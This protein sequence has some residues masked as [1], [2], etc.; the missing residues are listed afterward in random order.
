MQVDAAQSPPA[1]AASPSVTAATV[2]AIPPPA[3]ASTHSNVSTTITD[4]A[5]ASFN[6]SD[7]VRTALTNTF[8]EY[9]TELKAL[10]KAQSSLD[11]FQHIVKSTDG[12]LPAGLR[13]KI[14]KSARFTAVDT[15]DF[16]QAEMT[17][18]KRIELTASKQIAETM[19]KAKQRLIDHLRSIANPIS[20]IT[21]AVLKFT[22]TVGEYAD[23]W[24][25]KLHPSA[26]I[27]AS[28]AAAPATSNVN[29]S[30]RFPRQSA[31]EHFEREL[32][33]KVDHHTTKEIQDSMLAKAAE[34]A[35]VT[36]ER[37][38]KERVV[39]GV[40]TRELITDIATQATEK[41]V[42]A[43]LKPLKRKLRQLET[44]EANAAP[45]TSVLTDAP[46]PKRARTSNKRAQSS[47]NTRTHSSKNNSRAPGVY[48][49]EPPIESEYVFNFAP[50]I[51]QQSF[52]SNSS[53]RHRHTNSI[54]REND[55]DA[56]L[57]DTS[58]SDTDSPT[59]SSKPSSSN[60]GPV[61]F[62]SGGDPHNTHHRSRPHQRS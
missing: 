14:V 21:K 3:D 12:A 61:H 41:H 24:E 17:E 56:E 50:G 42:N 31:I 60:R 59:R 47:H 9:L 7:I 33:S 55:T 15:P 39:S 30:Y 46:A 25:Q 29:E 2:T 58:D 49:H 53:H 35:K 27:H 36:E 51:V 20:F 13:L 52:T 6:A 18:L 34:K 4:N 37:D 48:L 22:N 62:T 43:T 19:V 11:S 57:Y 54:Q 28:S 44:K 5:V 45:K 38:A 16:Y 32:R 1:A 40:N 23:A 26:H 10:K 8:G